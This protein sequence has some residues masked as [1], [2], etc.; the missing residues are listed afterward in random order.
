M[1]YLLPLLLLTACTQDY[2]E[3]SANGPGKPC[4]LMGFTSSIAVQIES[5][6]TIPGKLSGAVNGMPLVNECTL[7]SDNSQYMVARTGY[8]SV[9]IVL[10]VTGNAALTD[11]FFNQDGTPK[12][13]QQFQFVVNGRDD[14]SS[15]TSQVYAT[16][17]TL[18]WEPVYANSKTCP[19]AGYMATV[20]D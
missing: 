3:D 7:G 19:V 14:C 4:T 20:A 1:K 10:R 12:S 6:A 15:G 13:N 18:N 2:P 8:K 5:N 11:R 17:R 9:T 16:T